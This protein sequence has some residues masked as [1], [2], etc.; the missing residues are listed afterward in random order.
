MLSSRAPFTMLSK[1]GLC[2]VHDSSK[3][4]PSSTD[5]SISATLRWIILAMVLNEISGMVVGPAHCLKHA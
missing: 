2:F 5:E 3:F 1:N 4:L